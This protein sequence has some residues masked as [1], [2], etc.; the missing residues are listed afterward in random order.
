MLDMTIPAPG[1]GGTDPAASPVTVQPDK[2]QVTPQADKPAGDPQAQQAPAGESD[3]DPKDAA[4]GDDPSQDEKPKT[5]K[6]KRQER[7]RERWQEYK[8]ARDGALARLA[9]LESQVREI[10]GAT[11]PDFSQIADP[12]EELA[13]RTAWKVRQH[14]AGDI[15]RQAHAA[16]A[17]SDAA[18]MNA[19]KVKAEDTREKYPD[20]DQVFTGQTPIHER[21]V[22]FI[23]E[24]DKGGDLAY[25]LGKNPDAARALYEKFE[26][27]PAQALIEL[28]RIEAR[29]SASPPKTTSTA[30]KP[31]A[32]LGGGASPMA[33]D[34]SRASAD[35]MAAHLRKSGLIR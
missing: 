15:E 16:R 5:W 3:A 26:R 21:A 11:P 13:E 9:Y 33:F 27:A 7:N 12:N 4:S 22:P 25:F 14:Q 32:V 8:A 29:L 20:F 6:E 28:G 10:K 19:W 24:S 18:M 30:P 35:E 17:E 2:T 23:V 34:A 1:S 31:A